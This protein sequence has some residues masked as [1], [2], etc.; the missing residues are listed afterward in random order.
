MVKVTK[1]C[2]G[3]YAYRRTESYSFEFRSNL[4]MHFRF[5][6]KMIAVAWMTILAAVL[7]VFI[8]SG[9]SLEELVQAVKLKIDQL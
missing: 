4:K 6:K 9:L 1:T 7:V 8:G 5:N 2:L 3:Q